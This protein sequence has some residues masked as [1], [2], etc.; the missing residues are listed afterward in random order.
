MKLALLALSVLFLGSH[1]I[2]GDDDQDM[3]SD[4]DALISVAIARLNA[5]QNATQPTTKPTTRP[6]TQP[7]DAK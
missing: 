3:S 6:A 4:G 1:A 2:A 5:L 7:A